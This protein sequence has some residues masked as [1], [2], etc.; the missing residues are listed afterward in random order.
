MGGP[1]TPKRNPTWTELMSKTKIAIFWGLLTMVPVVFA[2]ISVLGY[3]LYGYVTYTIDYCGPFAVLDDEIGWVVA[4]DS[5]SCI[6]GRHGVFDD[7]AFTS[8]VYTNSDGARTG[9]GHAATA[10]GGILAIGDS[11][12]FGYGIDWQDTFAA[13]LSED[14]P[15][16]LLASPAYSGA[17]ALLLG[18]RAVDIVEPD[19]IVYLELGFWGR[20]VCTGSVRP[21]GI[22]KPC[23]WVDD[24]G[25]A[26]LVTPPAGHVLRM[27]RF[28]QRPG[29]MVGAGEKTLTYFLIARPIAK[30]NSILVRLG[31]RSGFAD[32]FEPVAPQQELDAIK[33]EHYGNLIGLAREAGAVLLLIDPYE[34]YR[35]ARAAAAPTDRVVYI[36]SDTWRVQVEGPMADLSPE[37]A[38]VP[39]D[40]HFGPG[41][42]RLI[43]DL[44]RHEITR[45]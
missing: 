24:A 25:R 19:Y 16:T 44:I 11:W 6:N 26:H 33:A 37:S 15:V 7:L 14:Y 17:Q 9:A 32:D 12:T 43:A 40:G 10:T 45:P 13:R 21:A 38:Y 27:A 2:V 1:L 34:V 36:S 30:L 5:E 42:H 28:G 39:S 41:T 4:P 35:D 23:Y 22:L 8:K 3:Y 29:G 20:A 18:Q 31:L